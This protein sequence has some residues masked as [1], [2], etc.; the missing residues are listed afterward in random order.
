MKITDSIERRARLTKVCPFCGS[1]EI[2]YLS[3][4]F[5]D[6]HNSD[7]GSM[8]VTCEACDTTVWSFPHQPMNYSDAVR[9]AVKKWNRRAAVA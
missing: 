8:E 1:N 7:S 5:Y 2:K 3:R 4:E 9:M 6:E